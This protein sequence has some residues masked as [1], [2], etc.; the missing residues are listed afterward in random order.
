MLELLAGKISHT[1]LLD[2]NDEQQ[3]EICKYGCEI[4][5]YT[6]ISTLGLILIGRLMGFMLETV[7]IVSVFYLCQSNGGGYH[8]STHA[9]CFITMAVGLAVSL[10]LTDVCNHHTL[11][12]MLFIVS[13]ILMATHPLCLHHNKQYLEVKNKHIKRRSRIVTTGIMVF[14][15]ANYIAGYNRIAQAGCVAM[16]MAAVSRL[17]ARSKSRRVSEMD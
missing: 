13:S 3:Y 17:T 1:L 8:A 4:W 12:F 10:Y 6:L 2:K 7:V 15:A 14:V 16:F 11:S 9:K 5:L